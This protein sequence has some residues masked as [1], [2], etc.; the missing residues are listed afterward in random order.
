MK[1]SRTRL[2]VALALALSLVPA[3]GLGAA[4][5]SRRLPPQAPQKKNPRPGQQETP[6]EQQQQEPLPQDIV[7]GTEETVK[8]ATNIVNVEAVVINK[9][10]KQ[11]VP[12]LKQG[13]FAVFE[14]NVQRDITNFS[15]PEAPITVTVVIEYSKLGSYFGYMASRGMEPGRYEVLRPLA[16][17]VSQVVRPPDDYVSV[18]AYDMRPTPLTDFTNDPARLNQVISLLLRNR[19]AFSEA[20]L[21]DALKLALIGGRADSVVLENSEA[22]TMEYSGMA[23]LGGNRRKAIFLISSGIDTFSKI[24]YDQARKIAQNAGV[25]IYIAGTGEMFMKLYG[26]DLSPTDGLGG[27]TTP[28]RMTMLQARNQLRTFAEETGGAYF[29]ITWENELP[30]AMHNINVLLRNQYSLAY[31]PGPALDEKAKRRKIVVKVDVDGDGK[32]DEKDYE[33]RARQFYNPPKPG[34]AQNAGR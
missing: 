32:Y 24:N 34:P 19:P 5:Q 13:N 8:V 2:I 10:T 23:S 31:T 1:Q 12:G 28:G 20:N 6:A 21:F 7:P 4:A 22:R 29:P 14:D 16:A 9:K 17:F 18:I 3:F 30:S 15:T 26:D 33:V 27:A 11:I 25:P